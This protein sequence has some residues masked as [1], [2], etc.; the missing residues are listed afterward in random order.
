VTKALKKGD[1]PLLMLGFNRRFAP[2]ALKLKAFVDRRQEPLYA[3]F[4]VNANLIPADHWI[5]DLKVGG[6]RIIGEGCHFIDFLTFLVGEVPVEVTATG[7]P[8]K[9][10][11]SEDN[12]MMTFRFADGSVGVVSYLANGDKSFPKEY[13]EVFTGGRVAVLN[14]WRRLELV[15]NGKR[16]VT[17][18]LL[19]QDKG[20]KDAW[21]AFLKAVGQGQE[22]PI[23]YEQLIG[24]TQASF[25]A[26]ESLR[27]GKPVKI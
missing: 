1:Q 2:L 5:N 16:K 11:Y 23:P 20:H 9:G 26:V 15:A 24:V 3:H 6:G 18:S 8:D 7:L 21:R 12:V 22:P 19:S 17:R 27:N 14:D 4:R 10:K 13:V 25:A